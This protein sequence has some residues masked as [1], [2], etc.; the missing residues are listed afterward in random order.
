MKKCPEVPRCFQWIFDLECSAHSGPER[1]IILTWDFVA[2]R[3]FSSK[4]WLVSPEWIYSTENS[5][6]PVLI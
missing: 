6:K 5:E 1:L 3:A 2:S 4:T